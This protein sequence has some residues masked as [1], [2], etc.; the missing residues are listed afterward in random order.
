MLKAKKKQIFADCDTRADDKKK[1][2][3][4]GKKRGRG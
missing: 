2:K 3:K 1:K 4:T